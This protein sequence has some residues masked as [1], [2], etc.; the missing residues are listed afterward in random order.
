M[1]T[2]DQRSCASVA[3]GASGTAFVEEL[4]HAGQAFVFE[5]QLEGLAHGGGLYL[6]DHQALFFHLV[7]KRR[8]AARLLPPAKTLRFYRGCVARSSH[9]S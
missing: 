6:I 8:T 1:A 2:S 7:A 9:S 3:D 4:G 5:K